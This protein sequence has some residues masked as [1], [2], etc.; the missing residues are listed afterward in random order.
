MN[1]WKIV[2]I[3]A[4]SL[5]VVALLICGLMYFSYTNAE[6][7]QRNLVET[8]KVNYE[9]SYDQLF[10]T[11]QQVAQVPEAAKKAF[12]EMYI[13]LMEARYG[14]EDQ[15]LMKW[16]QEQN[17][18]FDFSLYANVQKAVETHR[19]T[20][21]QAGRKLKAMQMEHVNMLTTVPSRWFVGDK[22]S[23]KV[24]IV[25]STKAK[26]VIETGVDNDVNLFD[27]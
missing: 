16:I 19:E 12:K 24:T 2:G 22:D 1:I 4:A 17:P 5:A 9:A 27:N 14:N 7:R 23:I 10:K 6:I 21:F 15:M 8:E 25:T 3:T 11:L 20:F 13:P 18:V 26:K